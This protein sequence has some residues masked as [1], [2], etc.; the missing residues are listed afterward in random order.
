MGRDW[1]FDYSRAPVVVIRLPDAAGGG[2]PDI[3]AMLR[4]ADAMLARRARVA[5]V[6]DL[7][8][9]RADATRRRR[10]TRWFEANSAEIRRYVVG[11]AVIAP[12]AV[13]RGLIV[14]VQWVVKPSIPFQVFGEFAPAL[15]WAERRAA[16]EGVLPAR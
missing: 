15:A 2:P 13:Q 10:A 9:S 11:Y 7:T 8:H 5:I 12:T 4:E 1:S 3:E 16:D 14:A 6:H